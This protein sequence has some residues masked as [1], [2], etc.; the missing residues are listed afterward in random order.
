MA[1]FGADGVVVVGAEVFNFDVEGF[2][3]GDEGVFECAAEY[4][5]SGDD[6]DTVVIG[7]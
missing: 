1:D 3:V 2:E 4:V 7:G 5:G 6:F